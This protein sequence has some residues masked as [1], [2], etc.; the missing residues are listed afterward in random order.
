[1]PKEPIAVYCEDFLYDASNGD[2][3]T[4][5]IFYALI[6]ENGEQKRIKIE[7]FFRKSEITEK[8]DYP[9]WV[10]ITHDEYEKRRNNHGECRQ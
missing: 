7:R 3:D 9:G 6:N 5:G 8:G 4:V 1:M 2:F 10:E